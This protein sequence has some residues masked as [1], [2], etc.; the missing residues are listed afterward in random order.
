[1]QAELKK[2]LVTGFE[3]F[4]GSQLNPSQLLVTALKK[5]EIPG[6]TLETLILPVE[7]E[8]ASEQLLSKVRECNP[9]L[10]ISFGQAEGREAITPEKIA[11]N[12]DDARIP[13]NSGDQRSNQTIIDSA[14]DGYFSTLPVER[15]VEAIKAEGISSQLSL[16]AG[17]FVCNHI[18]FM[19]QHSLRGTGIKSGFIHLPL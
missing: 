18:F 6:A 19:L 1:M 3:P 2:I 13:D 11:I 14:P 16:S 9:A 7:F 17:A 8:A 4:A 15:M 10:V 12:L 5:E